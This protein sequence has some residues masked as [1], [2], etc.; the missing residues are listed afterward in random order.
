MRISARVWWTL[1][2]AALFLVSVVALGAV[3]IQETH[4]ETERIVSVLETQARDARNQSIRI[5]VLTISCVGQLPVEER[6]NE[7]LD[8]CI[9][10]GLAEAGD[11]IEE[12]TG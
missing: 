8:Q 1:L 11:I 2:V 10:E 9:R 12:E 7:A 6:T 3:L 5:N 4:E